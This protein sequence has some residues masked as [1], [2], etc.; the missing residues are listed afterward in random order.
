MFGLIVVS[1]ISGQIV[2]R[3][4]KYRIAGHRRQVIFAI[5]MFLL[6]T[7]AVDIPALADAPPTWSSWAWAWASPSRSTR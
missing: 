2:S 7:M 4:G 1:I 6:S 3:T 5:G